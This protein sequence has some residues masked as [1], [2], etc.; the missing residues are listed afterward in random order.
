MATHRVP[1]P[2]TP[3]IR[4]RHTRHNNN[5]PILHPFDLRIRIIALP[6]HQLPHRRRRV[7]QRKERRHAIRLEAFLQI[8]RSRSIERGRPEKTGRAYPDVE[9]A[10]GVEDFVDEG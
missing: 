4:T 10:E 8:A 2:P 6:Q 9:T 7:L 1:D 5:A 3:T